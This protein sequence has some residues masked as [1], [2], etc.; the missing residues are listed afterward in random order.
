LGAAGWR[1]WYPALGAVIPWA[2]PCGVRG[3]GCT[4]AVSMGAIP[5]AGDARRRRRDRVAAGM[6]EAGPG[7]RHDA[8]GPVVRRVPG[9]EPG[10]LH[11]RRRCRRLR[12]QRARG[13]ARAARRRGTVPSAEGHRP[14]PVPGLTAQVGLT[15]TKNARSRPG[16]ART[17]HPETEAGET[18]KRV[19]ALFTWG[20]HSMPRRTLGAP[21]FGGHGA[22]RRPPAEATTA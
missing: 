2:N 18:P 14:A 15:R 10:L 4:G 3:R 22:T 7:G 13:R 19:W 8:V 20:H 16:W 21:R 17:R 6:A 1:R 9:S 11:R 5:A 12:H